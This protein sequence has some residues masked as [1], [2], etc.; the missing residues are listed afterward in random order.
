MTVLDR[1]QTQTESAVDLPLLSVVS[2]AANQVIYRTAPAEDGKSLV[3][4]VTETA[5]ESADAL[6]NRLKEAEFLP[7]PNLVPVFRSG[8]FE[9]DGAFHVYFVTEAFNFTFRDVVVKEP[10]DLNVVRELVLPLTA[11]LNYLHRESLVYCALQA[12]SVWNV[13]G[14]WKLADYTEL[15]M[16]GKYRGSD[17]RHLLIRPDLNT[18]PEAYEGLVS[19]AWDA[20][21]LGL[22]L[23]KTLAHGGEIRGDKKERADNRNHP[24]AIP[25]PLGDT[26]RE[27]LETD[28]IH[29]LSVSSFAE[30][31]STMVLDPEPVAPEPVVQA[32]PPAETI[33]A[34]AFVPIPSFYAE[35]PVKKTPARKSL[36]RSSAEALAVGA[37]VV[38]FAFLFVWLFHPSGTPV[39]VQQKPL[40]KEQPAHKT[41]TKPAARTQPVPVPDIAVAPSQQSAR[42]QITAVLNKWVDSTRE[43]NVAEQVECYAPVVDQLFG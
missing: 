29:R 39:H 37:L 41:E 16:E 8:S 14:T 36:A 25:A 5:R 18:P 28:P 17:T 38:I 27:L 30:R 6:L 33:E 43:R 9:A 4:V 15:R 21:S 19:P 35:R 2:R 10:F 20:W 40:A 13:G 1:E 3:A 11:A 24:H 31:L 32:T 26:V 42:A 34:A 23:N 12:G 22:L 7:H